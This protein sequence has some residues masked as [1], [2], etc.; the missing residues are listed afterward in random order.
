MPTQ[1]QMVLVENPGSSQ[2]SIEVGVIGNQNYISI[3]S[4]SEYIEETIN[5]D[6]TE[7]QSQ[8]LF[9]LKEEQSGS[10]YRPK[11]EILSISDDESKSDKQ[12]F[13]FLQ[14]LIKDLNLPIFTDFQT[15][16]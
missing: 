8:S 3:H 10:E 12:V 2:N 5:S 7:E 1:E 16:K 14:N 11:P 15:K 13:K 4:N 6:N 9:S